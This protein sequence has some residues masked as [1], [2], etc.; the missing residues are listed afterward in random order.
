MQLLKKEDKGLKLT[1]VKPGQFVCRKGSKD[2]TQGSKQGF[3]IDFQGLRPKLVLRL[4]VTFGS[5][6]Y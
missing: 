3:D 1:H 6:K 2:D 5:N 4:L